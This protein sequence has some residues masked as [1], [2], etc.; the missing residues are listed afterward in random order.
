MSRL[1]PTILKARL[2]VVLTFEAQVGVDDAL[3]AWTAVEPDAC[4]ARMGPRLIEAIVQAAGTDA[5][6]PLVIYA[7]SIL[8]RQLQEVRD[9][10][11]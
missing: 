7:S 6:L 9:G 2:D 10:C 5:V 11:L 3:S 1:S 4:D 8:R